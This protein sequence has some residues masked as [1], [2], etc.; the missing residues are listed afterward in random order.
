MAGVFF[1]HYCDCL[2]SITTF[3]RLQYLILTIIVAWYI[4]SWLYRQSSLRLERMP[5][6]KATAT[7]LTGSADE[8]YSAGVAQLC[9]WLLQQLRRGEDAE[10]YRD[11]GGHI[12]Q[13]MLSTQHDEAST[14]SAAREGLSKLLQ[15]MLPQLRAPPAGT[16]HSSAQMP[17]A[18]AISPAFRETVRRLWQQHCSQQSPQVAELLTSL[19]WRV[20]C[21]RRI[22]MLGYRHA[23]KQLF[24]YLTLRTSTRAK[25]GT[26]E[27]KFEDKSTVDDITAT[28][29][30]L[31][32]IERQGAHGRVQ[33]FM[34]VSKK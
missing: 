8:R 13:F 18:A 14:V 17:A 32:L 9:Q 16:G 27:E 15:D 31:S 5:F 21:Q 20:R 6:L 30:L 11:K 23:A 12:L 22:A 19:L 1:L 34:G 28:L 24:T 29:R 33:C 10:Y 4:C 26:R 2:I 25:D 3:I 7:G